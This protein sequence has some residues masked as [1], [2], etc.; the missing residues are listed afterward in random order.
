M[1][2][3]LIVGGSDAGISA[4]LR[5]REVDPTVEP[6]LVVDDAYPNFAICGIP[7]D[8]SGEVPDWRSLANRTRADLEAAG[9]EL[10]LNTHAQTIDPVARRLTVTGPDGQEERL[11]YDV[12]VVGTGAVPVR[13]PIEGLST[14]GADDGVHLLHTMDD[15]FALTA[16]LA[17]K[18][19]T[20]L[21]VGAGYIGLEMAEALRTRAS[22]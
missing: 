14:L 3:L 15:T 6:L 5:A 18:P 1:T 4:G 16:S 17:R 10:R 11:P 8:V 7:Y 20:A 2:R 9:L 19:A 13:P 22:T 21:I 12:L